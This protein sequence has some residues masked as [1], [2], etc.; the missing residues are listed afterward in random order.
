ME[1]KPIIEVY[2]PV[3]RPTGDRVD[4]TFKPG[5]EPLHG[6]APTPPTGGSGVQFPPAKKAVKD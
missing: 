5:A 3:K 6:A 1:R 2:A 4:L